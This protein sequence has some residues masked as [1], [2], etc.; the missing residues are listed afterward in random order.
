MHKQT[1]QLIQEAREKMKSCQDP[2]H[3]LSHVERVV[4]HTKEIA[5][6]YD[7]TQNQR[8]ALELAAWWHDVGRTVTKRPSFVMLTLIDDTISALMLWWST[9]RRGMFGEVV[10]LSTRIIFSKSMTAGFLGRPFLMKKN[11]ILVEILTDADKLDI[12]NEH[13]AVQLFPIVESSMLYASGYKLGAWWLFARNHIQLSTEEAK[14]IFKIL[15]KQF[16]SWLEESQIY[17]WHVTH[18]GKPFIDKQIF[19]LK[20]TYASL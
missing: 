14:Q 15:L 13:R 1:P 16:I 4:A 10:G 8:E 17:S 7:L 18:T 9:I 6:H 11:R 5:R 2:Y 12:I 3:D 20:Q 19:A